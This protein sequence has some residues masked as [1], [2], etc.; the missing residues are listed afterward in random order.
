MSNKK[1]WENIYTTKTPQ[2]VSWTQE[3]P[4]TSLDLI[5]KFDLPK[6][7][8]IIDIGGG[9]SLL[10][11]H[12]LAL[13]YTNV[14]VLD[15]SEAAIERAKKRLGEQANKVTWIVKDITKFSPGQSYDLWHD[16]AVFHFLT[17]EIHIDSYLDKVSKYT[18]HLVLGTFSKTGPLKCSGL[19]IKQYN[20]EDIQNTFAKEFQIMESFYQDHITPFDTIQNFTFARMTHNQFGLK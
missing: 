4:Q 8:H 14:S 2:E 20:V 9:D 19:E 11:D 16:R 13:G 1:H 5:A 12:L 3:V 15:I 7:A 18:R 10:V 17:N 6:F